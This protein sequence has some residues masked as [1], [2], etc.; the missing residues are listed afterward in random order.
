MEKETAEREAERF[1]DYNRRASDASR[2]AVAAVVLLNSGAWLAMM[3]QIGSLAALDPQP[4]IATPFLLWSGGASLGVV[5]W[6][7]VSHIPQV[8]L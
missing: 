1:D 8:N 7:I 2:T 5:T 4:S 6:L 3:S